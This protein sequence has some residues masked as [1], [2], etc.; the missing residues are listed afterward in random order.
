MV[1]NNVIEYCNKNNMSISAFEKKCSLPNGLVSKWNE[2]GYQ[3]SIS[4]LQKISSAT[5]IPIE[6]W[7]K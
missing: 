2:K 5:K 1:Y 4:T 7:L 6:K 3:P